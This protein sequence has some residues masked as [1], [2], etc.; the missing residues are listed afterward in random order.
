MTINDIPAGLSLD[1]L[2]RTINDRLRL[3]AERI[4]S[5]AVTRSNLDMANFRVV[6]LGDPLNPQ[7]ALNLRSADGRYAT[8]SF[9]TKA[10]QQQ[11]SNSTPAASGAT[12]TLI[13]TVPGTLAVQSNAAPIVVFSTARSFSSV[14]ILA[15]QAPV[16]GSITILGRAGPGQLGSV[17]IPDGGT[18][19]VTKSVSWN[20]PANT[21]LMFDLTSVGLTFPG[22]GLTIELS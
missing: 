10:V 11:T 12:G 9:V 21:L 4:G 5:A 1:K 16:G 22:S 6:N 18:K 14:T 13:L 8:P 3:I 7:D 17:S 20:L 15:T 19:P 2:T